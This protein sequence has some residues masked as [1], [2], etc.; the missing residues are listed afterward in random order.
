MRFLV[1]TGGGNGN[2]IHS[3]ALVAELAQWGEVD[4]WVGGRIGQN[5]AKWTV[6][7]RVVRAIGPSAGLTY[8]GETYDG[9][10]LCSLLRWAG[11][12]G[13]RPSGLRGGRAGP[14]A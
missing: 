3:T 4:F 7:R 14:A 2:V 10:C 5:Y 12:E 1:G 8:G 6:P 11:R 13:W 9:V